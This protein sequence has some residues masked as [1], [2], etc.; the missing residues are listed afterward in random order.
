MLF[1]EKWSEGYI[2]PIHKKGSKSD[3]G[4]YRGVTILSVVGKLFTKILNNRLTHWAE[5]YSVYFDAQAGFRAG[6]ST[7]DN[8]F[9]LHGLIAHSINS[10][11][12]PI[13]YF[14]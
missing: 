12:N 7:V 6:H 14:R 9:I 3:V 5:K 8:I 11:K 2:I 10:K 1:L 13:L 4:N